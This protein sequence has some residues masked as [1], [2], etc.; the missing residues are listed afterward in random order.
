M[1]ELAPAGH[2]DVRTSAQGGH[3]RH[4]TR[5]E[6]SQHG[7]FAVYCEYTGVE[8]VTLETTVGAAGRC[9]GKSKSKNILNP[10]LH[11][12]Q[13]RGP[14]LATE[15]L[16]EKNGG[17]EN[18]D[19]LRSSRRCWGHA[20]VG[21]AVGSAVGVGV[22]GVG[23]GRVAPSVPRCLLSRTSFFRFYSTR[24]HVG[25]SAPKAPRKQFRF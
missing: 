11:G 25:F 12:F 17:K 9:M 15:G 24:I 8:T 21:A 2:G 20:S 14:T 4:G 19:F 23:V 10:N 1:H 6:E 16:T 7:K 13:R 22:V 3:C 5:K 18:F